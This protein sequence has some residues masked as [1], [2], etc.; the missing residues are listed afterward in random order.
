VI[1]RLASFGLPRAVMMY[2]ANSLNIP[3]SYPFPTELL[4]SGKRIRLFIA[5]QASQCSHD[6]RR[7]AEFRELAAVDRAHQLPD[8]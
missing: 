5:N 2:S 8:A 6:R 4:D 3:F 1:V 7:I